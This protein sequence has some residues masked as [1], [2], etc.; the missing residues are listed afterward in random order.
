[1]YVCIT[2][3][4]DWNG[5]P[6]M[7]TYDYTL[8]DIAEHPA[9]EYLDGFVSPAVFIGRYV[10]IKACTAYFNEM[11]TLEKGASVY[12]RAFQSN[13]DCAYSSPIWIESM[14]V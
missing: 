6:L 12:V 4:A 11:L 10:P 1:S 9:S 14:C 3:K 7:K 2:V 8:K 5:T 13:G